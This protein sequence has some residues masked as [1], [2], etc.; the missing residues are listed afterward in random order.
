[1][2]EA[3]DN[4]IK[5]YKY[6]ETAETSWSQT[7]LYFIVEILVGLKRY[8]EALNI[9]K[10]A[11]SIWPAAPDFVFWKGDIYF[12]QGQYDDAKEIYKSIISNQTTYS[13]I[14]HHFDRKSFLPKER[15]GLI[16]ELE[17]TMSKH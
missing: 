3:L 9:I 12:L 10:D 6:K 16:F 5:A 8:E 17:K 4:F 7:C 1:M 2:N 13:E 14:I 15:L 11:E